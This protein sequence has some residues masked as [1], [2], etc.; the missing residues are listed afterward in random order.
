M[1]KSNVSL[2]NR[3]LIWQYEHSNAVIGVALFCAFTLIKSIAV[4]EL[5]ANPLLAT[6]RMMGVVEYVTVKPINPYDMVGHNLYYTYD[7]RL[8]NDNTHISIDDD[9][10]RPHLVGSVIP[11][12]R[13]HH[14]HGVDT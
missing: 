9:V 10:R 3:L 8:D 13:Q 12:E 5:Q 7:V 14:K 11:I 4:V 6:Q 1:N 2:R